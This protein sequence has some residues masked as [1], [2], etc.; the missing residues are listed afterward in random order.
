MKNYRYR[1]G[2]VVLLMLTFKTR[3]QRRDFNA[4]RTRKVVEMHVFALCASQRCCCR[5]ASH[6]QRLHSI[7]ST[8]PVKRVPG[9]DRNTAEWGATEEI[10][11]AASDGDVVRIR[12]LVSS[13]VK[14][15]AQVLYCCLLHLIMLFTVRSQGLLY[16]WQGSSF[17]L[18][19]SMS[20]SPDA[21]HVHEIPLWMQIGRLR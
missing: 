7:E 20:I 3:E 4:A 16:V 2:H 17:R 18:V 19:M 9:S 5:C 10:F 8:I 13:G 21:C 6:A 11:A 14:V 1:R 12:D 15:D